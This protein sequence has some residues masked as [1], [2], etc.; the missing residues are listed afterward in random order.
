VNQAQLHLV[1]SHAPVFGCLA[2]LPMLLIAEIRNSDLLRKIACWYLLASAAAACGAYFTGPGALELLEQ[3]AD[4]DQEIVEAH[5]LLG[6]ASFVGMI[7]LGAA[8]LI[9]LLQYMQ[10]D[11]CTAWLRGGLIALVLAHIALLAV[12]SRQGGMIRHPE[13]H[14][15][16]KTVPDAS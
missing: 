5:A 9:A 10:E 12:T 11:R 6:R 14:P 1:L 16:S 3:F 15:P 7:I 13:A 8:A 2:A 4:T